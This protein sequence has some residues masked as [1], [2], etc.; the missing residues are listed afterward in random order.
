MTENFNH[1]LYLRIISL[2][3]AVFFSN[4]R[5]GEVL[6]N[7]P[8]TN[9]QESFSD[10]LYLEV[11]LLLRQGLK[12]FEINL[13]QLELLK[14]SEEDMNFLTTLNIDLS[15]QKLQVIFYYCIRSAV[16]SVLFRFSMDKTKI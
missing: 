5:R 14:F 6:S 2:K 16:V 12:N 13:L 10:Q 8:K 4:C 3:I 7:Y 15:K 11:P 1:E 9:L